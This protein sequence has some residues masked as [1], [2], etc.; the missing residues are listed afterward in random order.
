MSELNLGVLLT[1]KD[2]NTS[3]Y[4]FQNYKIAGTVTRE[5]LT[6]DFAPFSFS[7]AVANLQGDNLDAGLI[8][9]ATKVTRVWAETAVVDGWMAFVDVV[10]LDDDSDIT[11][12]LHSYSGYVAAGGWDQTRIELSLNTVM[13]AVRASIPGRRMNEQLV[14]NIPITGQISV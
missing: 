13:D 14:G 7:G 11:S 1:L 4:N 12:V 5:G 6:Y 10:L 9:Q 8:F 3:K 2:G